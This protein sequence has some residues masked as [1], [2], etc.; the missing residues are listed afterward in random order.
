MRGQHR[1]SLQEIIQQLVSNDVEVKQL[2][3]TNIL[4]NSRIQTDHEED[5]WYNMQ[6]HDDYEISIYNDEVLIQLANAI[7]QN[8]TIEEFSISGVDSS[9]ALEWTGVGARAIG[10]ALKD[11][12]TLK[13]V[14][15]TLDP[16]RLNTNKIIGFLYCLTGSAKIKILDVDLYCARTDLINEL[17]EILKNNKTLESIAFRVRDTYQESALINFATGLAQDKTIK[18]LSIHNFRLND[19]GI[20]HL[21]QALNNS[22]KLELLDLQQC[23]LTQNGITFLSP[24]LTNSS[25]LTQL[26][27]NS[28]PL[29]LEGIQQLAVQL[30]S[31]KN[32]QN[33]S[34]RNTQMN[35]ESLSCLVTELINNPGVIS[36]LDCSGFL[37]DVASTQSIKKLI[38]ENSTLRSI[39]LD[40][41]NLNDQHLLELK[42]LLSNPKKCQL[43]HFGF[44]GIQLL[45]KESYKSLV[46]ILKKNGNLLTLDSPNCSPE[47]KHAMNVNQINKKIRYRNSQNEFINGSIELANCFFGK[48]PGSLKNTHIS[49]L[50]GDSILMIML[51][52]GRGTLGMKEDNILQ[53]STLILNNFATR[54][55]LITAGLYQPDEVTENNFYQRPV[56]GIVKWWSQS[57]RNQ[58]PIK[59]FCNAPAISEPIED[60]PKT[61]FIEQC[62]IM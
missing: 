8:T 37:F 11:H 47:L 33:L 14:N 12:P 36:S 15:L 52:L 17:G 44:S 54:R 58:Y 3:L 29:G 38:E 50:S 9:C 10:D 19:I 16:F 55:Q 40:S 57:T 30:A 42:D 43:E 56:Q 48:K 20:C 28:N 22:P 59:V 41:S 49:E 6:S 21:A 13:H 23:G 18:R 32:L 24:I 61:S 1:I 7:R 45:S 4:G 25:S 26:T 5:N 34:L 2:N 31:F 39:H 51:Y 35:H 60:T 62:R 46:N 27:L 53:C